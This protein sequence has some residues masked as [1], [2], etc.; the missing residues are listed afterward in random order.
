MLQVR[1]FIYTGKHE[2]WYSVS[3]E[4]FHPTSGVESILDPATGQKITISKETGRP[5]EWTSE[6]NYHFRLS[7]MAPRLLEFY[8][9]NPEFVVPH[10]RYLDVISSV[11]RGLEDLSISRPRERLTWGIPVPSD[12][13]QTIYVWLDALV[14]YITASGYPWTPGSP[15]TW[16]ADL[17]VVGKDIAKFH[18]VYWPAF[19]L[20]LDIPPPKQ[21]LTHAHWTMN[22]KKMSKTDG[23][24]VNPFY[25]IQRYGVDTMRFYMAHDGGINDDGDYSN[26]KI[27]ERYKHELQGGLGNLVSRVCGKNFD[28]VAA[29]SQ[30][31]SGLAGGWN[32]NTRDH[33]LRT[34]AEMTTE[35][36]AELMNK[37]DVPN[38]LKKTISLV[39]ETN[40][41]L[42]HAA[43]WTLK[44]EGEKNLQN[45]IIFLS[46]ECIRIAGILL[47]PFMPDKAKEVLNHLSVEKTKRSF[48]YAAFGADDTYGVGTKGKKGM[49]FPPLSE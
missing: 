25:A 45:K 20:A 18:C 28:I 4:T 3:D 7:S 5:V 39:H 12:S 48:E 37:L 16:P 44:S 27:V 40:K 26:E 29:R 1:D 31:V 6:T 10:A 30:S 41:Y 42:Q 49:V 43:P 8:E 47:Q 11:E 2:G 24:V 21:I 17:H 23:N 46:S 33:L 9:K 14:N 35:D 22:R 13:T 38:A 32:F 36:V 34:S 19:L 15:S